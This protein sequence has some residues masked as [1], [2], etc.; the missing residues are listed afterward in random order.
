M[1]FSS[2]LLWNNQIIITVMM[3]LFCFSL[4]YIHLDLHHVCLCVCRKAYMWF[5]MYL[6]GILTSVPCLWVWHDMQEDTKSITETECWISDRSISIMYRQGGHDG[7]QWM[8]SPFNWRMQ[9]FIST[10]HQLPPLTLRAV[11]YSA[12]LCVCLSSARGAL[13]PA[14]TMK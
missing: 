9:N 14:M 10:S 11:Y 1:R 3:L 6:C 7:K 2:V 5:F 8:I 12:T 4:A 13:H